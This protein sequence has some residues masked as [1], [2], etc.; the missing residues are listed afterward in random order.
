[1]NEKV[2]N[3][4]LA[5]IDEINVNVPEEGQLSKSQDTVLFGSGGKLD[6]LGL[7]NFIL[8]VEDKIEEEFGE[9]I[10]LATESA[11]SQKSS[12]FANV[13][14]LATHIDLL[15]KEKCDA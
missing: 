10:T 8:T 2:L 7:V 11:L 15:L 1:M 5:S 6:S 9:R 12:P 14:M 4:I 3:A 13:R